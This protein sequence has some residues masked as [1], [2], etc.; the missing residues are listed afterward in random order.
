VRCAMFSVSS[1]FPAKIDS[2]RANC[3]EPQHLKIVD[4]AFSRPGGPSAQI[5]KDRICP[6]CE[7]GVACLTWSMTFREEGVWGGLSPYQRTQ[8]GAPPKVV[9]AGDEEDRDDPGAN[10]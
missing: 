7:I 8:H 4:A 1:R 3:A 5:M 10:N 6:G 9:R 2:G